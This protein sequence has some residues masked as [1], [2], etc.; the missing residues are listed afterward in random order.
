MNNQIAKNIKM[1]REAA[2]LSQQALAECLH[3]SR[4]AISNWERGVSQPDLDS[5]F[6]L[7]SE[8][9]VDVTEII[10]GKRPDDEF[11]A[12]KP[13]RIKAT[14]IMGIAFFIAILLS[15][16]LVPYFYAIRM[17]YMATFTALSVTVLPVTYVIGTMFTLSLF[18]IWLDFRISN[19]RAGTILIISAFLLIFL[20]AVINLIIICGSDALKVYLNDKF[21][22]AIYFNWLL[23]YPVVFIIPGAMLFFG[24]NRKPQP[25]AETTQTVQETMPI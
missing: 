16:T 7:A 6:L 5:I 18:S 2:H 19:K 23:N 17:H 4:Q 20:D 25:S 14:I 22:L 24:F 15:T 3:V 10:Y 9:Q 12:S 8:F 1:Y 21:Q 13:K 11:L